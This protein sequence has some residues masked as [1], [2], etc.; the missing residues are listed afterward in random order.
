MTIHKTKCPLFV[1]YASHKLHRI[2]LRKV[3]VFRTSMTKFP[4]ALDF[5][6]FHVLQEFG[7]VHWTKV[8]KH[9]MHLKKRDKYD[10]NQH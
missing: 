6:K 9:A 3:R 2:P 5:W 7:T 8:T 1:V 4:E 10:S